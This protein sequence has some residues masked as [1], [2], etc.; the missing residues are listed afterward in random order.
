MMLGHG[1]GFGW[2]LMGVAVLVLAAIITLIVLLATR[3]V[4]G[5]QGPVGPHGAPPRSGARRIL[6]ERYA[7]GELTAEQYREMVRV[8][9]EQ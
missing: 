2:G 8:L 3:A 5:M 7:R 1:F 6:D 4:P 9:E